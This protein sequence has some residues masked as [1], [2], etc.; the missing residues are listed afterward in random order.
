MSYVRLW[1]ADAAEGADRTGQWLDWFDAN[2]VEAIG[3][4]LVT[5]RAGGHANPTVRVEDLRQPVDQP[6]G[7]QV[8]AWFDRQDR[9]RGED[10]LRLR[11]RVAAG[12]RLHQEATLTATGWSVDRQVLAL[13]GGL[14]W[15]EETDPLVLALLGGCD[16]TLA[17]QDQLT[18][19]AA[20]HD[21]TEEAL[22]EV[23]A[24]LVTHL[25]ERGFLEIA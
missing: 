13:P 11:Y 23:A 17:L 15:S 16:G 25:V 7:E 3:F 2:K 12:L 14:R 1:L 5:L 21:V 19:L 24:P 10:P 9:L 8:A 4:G 22:A 20:A 6:L 18:V